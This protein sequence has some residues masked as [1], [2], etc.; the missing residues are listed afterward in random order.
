VHA[1]QDGILST[2][3]P[4]IGAGPGRFELD[5]KA[6]E[7]RVAEK[8]KFIDFQLTDI[9]TLCVCEYAPVAWPQESLP[10]RLDTFIKHLESQGEI[11]LKISNHTLARSEADGQ[12]VHTISP[13]KDSC[14]LLLEK[15]P[16]TRSVPTIKNAGAYMDF[17]AS[18]ENTQYA[19]WLPS[20]LSTS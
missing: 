5:N 1:L 10:V 2:Q 16:K 7:I 12:I 4:L 8:N 6:A 13:E 20:F 9:D 15:F 11:N 14:M 19:H 3:Q 17:N 18:L